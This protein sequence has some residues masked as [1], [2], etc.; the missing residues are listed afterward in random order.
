MFE[1]AQCGS[2]R[3]RGFTGHGRNPETSYGA[4]IAILLVDD[5]DLMV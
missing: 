2:C 1:K 3:G 5:E 4:I